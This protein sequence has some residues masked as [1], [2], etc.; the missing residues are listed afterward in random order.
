MQRCYARVFRVMTR[1]VGRAAIRRGRRGGAPIVLVL[2]LLLNACAP[3]LPPAGAPG[4]PGATTPAPWSTTILTPP[5]GRPTVSASHAS[6]IEGFGRLPLSFVE[7]HGQTDPQV[8]YYVTSPDLT[9]YFSPGGLTYAVTGPTGP[10]P[11]LA[12]DDPRGQFCADRRAGR[13]LLDCPDT[14]LG[15]WAVKVDFVGAD[16][17]ARPVGLDRT[18]TIFSY[19]IQRP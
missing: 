19:F 4:G 14:P 9:L 16:Q 12:P 2:A 13:Y 1:S 7:N 11:A 15:R 8:A 3:S 6:P 17:A 10:A 18:E 5:I